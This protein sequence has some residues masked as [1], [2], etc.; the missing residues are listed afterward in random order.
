MQERKGRGMNWTCE[1]CGCRDFTSLAASAI[2]CHCRKALP[3][4]R[5]KKEAMHSCIVALA[6]AISPTCA[7][8]VNSPPARLA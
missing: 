3:A 4:S 1:I 7:S 5:C 6:R 8:H 2:A